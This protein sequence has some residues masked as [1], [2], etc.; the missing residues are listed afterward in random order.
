MVAAQPARPTPIAPSMELILRGT[1]FTKWIGW[2][3]R[4]GVCPNED[5]NPR[6]TPDARPGP[7]RIC[8]RVSIFGPRKSRRQYCPTLEQSS[9]RPLEAEI[10][11]A[12]KHTVSSRQPLLERP[13]TIGQ[14]ALLR[15]S[16]VSVGFDRVRELS[17]PWILLG[18]RASERHWYGDETTR[19][20]VAD[21]S[22]RR[23]VGSALLGW[24]GRQS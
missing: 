3:Q 8:P 22:Q 19:P 6:I 17:Q 9:P 16:A 12:C 24:T 1:G 23:L 21:H 13:R 14:D 4:N 20:P 10:Y 5:T 7:D 15:P 2:P 18:R 11:S